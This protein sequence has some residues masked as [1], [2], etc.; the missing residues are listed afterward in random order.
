MIEICAAFEV[1]AVA[2]RVVLAFLV[3]Q[4]RPSFAW[5]ILAT[6]CLIISHAAFWVWLG[7]VNAI[8]A[9]LTIDTLPANWMG[10]RTQWEHTHAARAL[11]QFIALGAL[12]FSI[13]V[14]TPS[15]V[16]TD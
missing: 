7:P 2:A 3:R 15:S 4:R 12:V 6:L 16:S 5:T 10:L 9:A 8:I 1:G 11:L 13:L 14:E